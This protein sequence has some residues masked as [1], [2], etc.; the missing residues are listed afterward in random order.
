MTALMDVRR[1]G[2]HAVSPARIIPAALPPVPAQL[3]RRRQPRFVAGATVV[4][5]TAPLLLLVLSLLVGGGP[6]NQTADDAVITMAARDATSRLVFDGPY[7][8]FQWHHPGPTY[9]Y[10]LGLP[11]RLWGGSPTGTLIGASV[12]ALIAAA[13]TVVA[14]WRWG[15]PRAGWWAAFAVLLVTCGWGPGYWRD[16]WNPYAVAFPVLFALVAAALAAAGARSA[17][18]WAA[19]AGSLAIQTH[20][21]TVPVITFPLLVAGGAQLTRWW[22]RRLRPVEDPPIPPSLPPLRL[23]RSATPWWRARP[24]LAV[25]TGLLATEWVLPVWDELF[26]RHN[27][28][29]IVSFFT[30][31]HPGHSWGESWRVTAA[32]LGV[33]L[34]QHHQGVRDAVSDE[35]TGITVAVFMLLAVVGIIAGWRYS[36]PLAVWL[37]GFGILSLLLA[38]ASVSRIVGFPY[39]YLLVWISALPALPIVAAAIGL[40]GLT[41][42]TLLR[43]RELLGSARSPAERVLN[44]LARPGAMVT[45]LSVTFA[46]LLGLRAVVRTPPAAALADPDIARA[47]AA[48]WPIVSRIKG[49]VRISLVDG[50][51]WPTAAGVGLQL[52]RAGHPL[53]VDPGWTFLFGARRRADGREQAS[54][55]VAGSDPGSWPL[56]ARATQI[57]VAGRAHVFVRREGPACWWGWVPFGGPACPVPVAPPTAGPPPAKA[58]VLPASSSR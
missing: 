21:S 1:K 43:D 40:S 24:D 57:G 58:G 45:V 8:R 39:K 20:V 52:E 5:A 53:H 25:G 38:V 28:S 36:K 44:G 18:I 13:A 41:S 54:L 31:R 30:A 33:S 56:G 27:L 48:V 46:S 23:K 42:S 2:T 32:V 7:S 3:A 11:T 51:R 50:E 49:P 9:L 12:L 29:A 26:G 14:V 35:H 22:R 10:I 34:H 15:G 6:S 19:V 4:A 17:L 16:P 47:S 55:I 37:G